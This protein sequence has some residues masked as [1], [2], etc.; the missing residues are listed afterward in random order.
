MIITEP[1][2]HVNESVL[3]LQRN[4]LLS[5]SLLHVFC[6]LTL[7]NVLFSHRTAIHSDFIGDRAN[8]MSGGQK[9]QLQSK[10][11]GNCRI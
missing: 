1:I 8:E 11:D 10:G 3:T 9:E 7:C 4:E 6:A 5:V 2:A